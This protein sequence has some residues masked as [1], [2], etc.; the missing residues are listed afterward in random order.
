MIQDDKA[1]KAHLLIDYQIA[2]FHMTKTDENDIF[3]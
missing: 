1:H 2:I 3:L